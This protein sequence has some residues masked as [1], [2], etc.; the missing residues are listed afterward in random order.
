MIGGFMEA[1]LVVTPQE[2]M[3]VRLIHDRLSENP[4]FKGEWSQTNKQTNKQKQL[5]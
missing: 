1:L 3:K 5:L 2:T 4:R